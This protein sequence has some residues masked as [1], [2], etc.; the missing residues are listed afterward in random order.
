[1]YQIKQ[2]LAE[3]TCVVRQAVLR[4]GKPIETCVFDGDSKKDTFHL[5]IF[6]KIE[7]IGVA[8]FIKNNSKLFSEKNQYQLRGMAI[9]KNFQQQGLGTL[10][11]NEAQNILLQ[12]KTELLWFHAREL[13]VTFYKK[14]GFIIVGDSFIIP[15]IG[16]HYVMYKKITSQK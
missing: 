16:I 15:N 7:L 5:G 13:A 10:I 9:L 3:E 12:N 4:I 8:S 14:Q 11:L 2:I 1:M 6:S